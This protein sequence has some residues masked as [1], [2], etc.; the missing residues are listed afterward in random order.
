[1]EATV[2]N[3]LIESYTATERPHVPKLLDVDGRF[4]LTECT[5]Q[6]LTYDMLDSPAKLFS[7]LHCAAM[8][9]DRFH[10]NNWVILDVKESNF[11]VPEYS[12]S[13]SVTM[14]D[15]CWF[16]DAELAQRFGDEISGLPGEEVVHCCCNIASL[17]LSVF[18]H[19][20]LLIFHFLH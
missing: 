5:G 14:I 8:T 15:H 3:E 10:S 20:V 17:S 13:S 2:L 7:F 6:E 11:T 16:V 9:M 4:V 18:D 1:M 19:S 12:S